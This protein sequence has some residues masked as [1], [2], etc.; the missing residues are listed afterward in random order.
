M[1]GPRDARKRHTRTEG[2]IVLCL[3]SAWAA[4]VSVTICYV[5]AGAIGPTAAASASDHLVF[6]IH[7]TTNMKSVRFARSLSVRLIAL[8]WMVLPLLL[9]SCNLQS[10][11]FIVTLPVH[12][13][14]FNALV[15]GGQVTVSVGSTTV[16]SGLPFE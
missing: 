4:L 5:A 12:I 11:G 1:H 2:P 7:S 14:V 16:A 10:G 15:D 3:P 9:T 8:A 6:A 13:R